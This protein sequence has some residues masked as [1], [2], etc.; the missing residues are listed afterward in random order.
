LTGDFELG[1][2]HYV[3][4]NGKFFVVAADYLEELNSFV[5]SISGPAT[6]LPPTTAATLE[7]D[8]N[9]EVARSGPEWLLLDKKTIKP[10][11][12]T[13]EIEICDLMS[14][15]ADWKGRP[16]QER[17]PFFSKVNLALK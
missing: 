6:T 7:D 2:A 5:E 9:K 15:L 11:A 3:L 10:A 14:V 12:R 16:P 13:T 8:Y 17:L 4:D 1:G